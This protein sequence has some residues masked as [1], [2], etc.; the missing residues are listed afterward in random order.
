M[1]VEQGLPWHPVAAGLAGQ[2]IPCAPPPQ[3]LRDPHPQYC[4]VRYATL[5]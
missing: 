4:A 1:P 5:E 3:A 2:A